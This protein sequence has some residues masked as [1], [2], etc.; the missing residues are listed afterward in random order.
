MHDSGAFAGPL[1]VAGMALVAPLGA[2]ALVVGAASAAGGAVL[3]RYVPIWAPWPRP[4]PPVVAAAPRR[5]PRSRARPRA[6]P[7]LGDAGAAAARSGRCWSA[8]RRGRPERTA[9]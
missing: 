7:F 4:S 8:R 1:V 2:A 5:P 9:S 3:W 6:R